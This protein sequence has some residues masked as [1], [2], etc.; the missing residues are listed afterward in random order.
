MENMITNE[1]L[2]RTVEISKKFEETGKDM[3]NIKYILKKLK[4]QIMRFNTFEV[5][6]EKKEEGKEKGGNEAL[7]PCCFC[8]AW[9]GSPPYLQGHK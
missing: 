5:Q 4:N 1:R 6:R 2:N 7:I 8:G 9:S 3:E